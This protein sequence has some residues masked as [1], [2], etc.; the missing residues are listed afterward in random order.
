M[1]PEM[2]NQEMNLRRQFDF[3]KATRGKFYS[4]YSKGHSTTIL[5][6]TPDY[7][8]PLD[9]HKSGLSTRKMGERILE[10]QIRA[11]GIQIK[12][13]LDDNGVDYYLSLE[14]MR[15][16][17]KISHPVKL[18]T[19]SK[20]TFALHKAY[21]RTPRT[22]IA[23][24]W[25]AHSPSETSV[26]ALT[27]EEALQIIRAKGYVN[28]V[29]WKEKGGYSVTN[30]GTELKQMLAPFRMTPERWQTKLRAI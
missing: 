25:R 28:T 3:S 11:A 27:Y 24:V 6:G 17:G 19:S 2:N 14:S 1:K 29:S 23:Y 30:A 4:R 26:Y 16:V 12:E 5:K 21:Q 13:S 15:N 22:L 20:E 9:S 10:S 18:V 7:S 8:D